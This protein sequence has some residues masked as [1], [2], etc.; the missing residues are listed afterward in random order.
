MNEYFKRLHIYLVTTVVIMIAC[1]SC[2][3]NETESVFKQVP[4]SQ[5]GIAFTNQ[6]E[7]KPLFSILYYL[8]YYNGGGVATGDINNDGLTDIFF[9][10][11]SKGNNKLYLN[12]GG[13]KFEDITVQA[14]VAG[15]SSPA[16]TAGVAG[17]AGVTG[18]VGLPPEPLLASS[19]LAAKP[20]AILSATIIA[21]HLVLIATFLLIARCAARFLSHA[22]RFHVAA[23]CTRRTSQRICD[24]NR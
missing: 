14:G 19:A 10:A 9:T 15:L 13:F 4:S 5:T 12:K 11:N 24:V 8:Y 2:R 7:E 17:V 22:S 23:N 21:N 18:V 1:L 3:Q 6:L 16:G 20:K